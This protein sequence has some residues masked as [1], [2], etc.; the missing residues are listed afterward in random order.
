MLCAFF[1]LLLVTSSRLALAADLP[2]T[3]SLGEASNLGLAANPTYRMAKTEVDAERGGRLSVEPWF[4]ANPV[5]G[6][7]AGVRDERDG[8]KNPSYSARLEQRIDLP[9][10]R[11]ARLEAADERITLAQRR[12]DVV[13]AEVR[14][15]VRGAYIAALIAK[16]RSEF[17]DSQVA[18]LQ[19]AFDAADTR[20]ASGAASDIERRLAEVELGLARVA[21]SQALGEEQRTLQE[22]RAAL[23]IP[24]DR[25]LLLNT[26]L[27]PPPG[28]DL[29]RSRLLQIAT[30]RR[31]ELL[32]LRQEG[33]AIDAEIERLRKERL[34]ALALAVTVEQDSPREYWVAPGVSIAP[35]VW[36]RYQGALAVAAADRQRQQVALEASE[37]SAARDLWLAC[38]LAE[39]RREEVG[40]FEATVLPAAERSRD[41]VFEGWQSG[42]FD[43]FR[44]LVAE[45][46]LVHSRLA[47]LDNL[48]AL[49][50]AEIEID[51]AL[52]VID[53]GDA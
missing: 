1:F 33:K 38:D 25:L 30:Q 35:P 27:A 13:G 53:D 47:Y 21:R 34:P 22:L 14:A 10:Q 40:L 7:D 5:I 43:I 19:R 41:L 2:L 17:T 29:D 3:L 44:V 8:G 52:G 42:K 11:T 9:G 48:T 26:P 4:P 23:A 51:R 18:F 24:Y 32:A 36:Q 16:R 20:A 45:R 28:H 15:R 49:W 37:Q 6:V 50:G 46:E 31:R 12:L 39:R